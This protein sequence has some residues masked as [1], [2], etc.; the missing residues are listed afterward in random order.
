MS[1]CY[2]VR[3]IGILIIHDEC[4]GVLIAIIIAVLIANMVTMMMEELSR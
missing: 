1:Y 2:C 4:P 3:V